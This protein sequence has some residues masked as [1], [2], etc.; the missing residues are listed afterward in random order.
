MY[1]NRFYSAILPAISVNPVSVWLLLTSF[2]CLSQSDFSIIVVVVVGLKCLT[3]FLLVFHK[4]P[5]ISWRRSY[6]RDIL[7]SCLL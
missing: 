1:S 3:A 7:L 2:F 4:G 6:L 5:D